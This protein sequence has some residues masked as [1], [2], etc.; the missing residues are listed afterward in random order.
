MASLL[1]ERYVAVWTASASRDIVVLVARMLLVPLFLM[2][3]FDKITDF[4]G[5]TAHIAA[6][7]LPFPALGVL[8]AVAVELGCGFLVLVGW[9]ARWAALALASFSI[10][11]GVF[12]HAYWSDTDSVARMVNYTNFWKNISI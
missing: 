2:S 7:G 8:I 3:G 1:S 6:Q 9:K 11:S 5:T 10:V 4:A 12:F